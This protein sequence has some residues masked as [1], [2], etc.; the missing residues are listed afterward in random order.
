MPGKRAGERAKEMQLGM[1]LSVKDKILSM[2]E[3]SFPSQGK[4]RA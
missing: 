4:V 1:Q 2:G 3:N